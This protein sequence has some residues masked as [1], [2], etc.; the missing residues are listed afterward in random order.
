MDVTKQP[1]IEIGQ[2]VVERAHFEHRED[3][4][5][6]DP[7]T[8]AGTLPLSLTTSYAL[9]LDGQQAAIRL[10]LTTDRTKRPLYVVEIVIVGIVRVKPGEANMPLHQY[11]A[12]HGAGLLFPFVREVVAALTGR[13]RFGPVWLH[14]VNFIASAALTHG[15]QPSAGVAEPQQK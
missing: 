13:G 11:A 3:Y 2:I 15:P 4:L 6:L 1:G 7:S 9:A 14:P 12:A 8:N 10:E 5:G